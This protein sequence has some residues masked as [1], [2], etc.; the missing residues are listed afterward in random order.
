MGEFK[1]Y[2]RFISDLRED[3]GKYTVLEKFPYTVGFTGVISVHRRFGSERMPTVYY[4]WNN[5]EMEFFSNDPARA[6]EVYEKVMGEFWRGGMK[7]FKV[8]DYVIYQNGDS[9]ELGRI[10]RLTDRGAFVFYHDG[11][12]AAMTPYDCIHRLVNAYTIKSTGLGGDFWS[13]EES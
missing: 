5:N 7:D 1:N 2:T 12:T 11:D 8:G 3:G 13:E 9:Y 6:V 10:K 4:V